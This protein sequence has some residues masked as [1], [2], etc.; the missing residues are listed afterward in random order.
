MATVLF[1]RL[2]PVTMPVAPCSAAYADRLMQTAATPAK[3]VTAVLIGPSPDS[4]YPDSS[5]K[6]FDIRPSRDL[7]TQ[8]SIQSCYAQQQLTE[9]SDADIRQTASRTRAPT[10][11]E[12]ELAATRRRPA[13]GSGEPCV[14]D[15][16]TRRFQ[17]AQMARC[18]SR[19]S[20]FIVASSCVLT[21]R[22]DRRSIT[23][24]F[25]AGKST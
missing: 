2:M 6:P 13:I 4:S 8:R 25:E 19:R 14:S 21:A 24:V 17:E 5:C 18:Q 10:T 9:C 12:H 11:P 16:Q 22:H 23:R 15:P 1:K 20:T 7:I 3:S